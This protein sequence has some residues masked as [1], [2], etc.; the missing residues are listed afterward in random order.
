MNFFRKVQHCF[1]LWEEGFSMAVPIQPF[2]IKVGVYLFLY[3]VDEE[4]NIEHYD[5]FK[6]TYV[7]KPIIIN[8]QNRKS[9]KSEECVICMVNP[10][11]VMMCNYGHICL[12]SACDSDN[13][14][15]CPLCKTKVTIKR[16]IE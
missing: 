10:T 15:Y 16:I 4:I 7:G 14:N 1:N 6:E 12:C 9:F 3:S 8:N 2:R 13:V 5:I 11:N